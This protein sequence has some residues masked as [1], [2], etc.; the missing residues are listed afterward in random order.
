MSRISAWPVLLSERNAMAGI[1][2]TFSKLPRLR[3]Q[4]DERL[5]FLDMPLTCGEAYLDPVTGV[6]GVRETPRKTSA[7]PAD[8]T[9]R[10][11]SMPARDAFVFLS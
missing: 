7:K 2:T 11:V 4:D 6:P 8:L 9:G 5:I 3:D 10:K 1:G